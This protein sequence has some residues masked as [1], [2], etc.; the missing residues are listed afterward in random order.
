MV[1]SGGNIYD[2]VGKKLWGVFNDAS[3][4]GI[5]GLVLLI[6]LACVRGKRIC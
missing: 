6:S 5:G 4:V 3:L 1:L 2:I